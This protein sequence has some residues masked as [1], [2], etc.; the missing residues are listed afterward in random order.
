[1]KRTDNSNRR[2]PRWARRLG[3]VVVAIII[4]LVV[5]GVIA[6]HQYYSNLKPANPS[7]H[8][9]SVQIVAGST[10][11]QIASTLANQNI[12]KSQWVF[13]LYVTRAGARDELKAGTY[14]LSPAMNVGEIVSILS[15]GR[16][17]T[18]LVTIVPGSRLSQVQHTLIDAGFNK[19]DVATAL[20]PSTYQGN[21][22]LVDKPNNAGLEGFLY[23]DSFAKASNTKPQQIVSESL[24][25]MAKHLTPQLRAAFAK[26]GLNVY[27]GITL[28]S[29][30]E[31]EAANA[32]DRA[33]VAQVFLSRL[34]SGATLGSDV[35][36]F[37]G[38]SVAGKSDLSPGAQLKL[39]TPYNTLIHK[40]LPP[41]PISNVSDSSL[42]AAA[43]PAGTDW[44][45]FVAGDNGK[46][47]FS[48]TLDQH[49]QQ[50]Q[51]YCHKLCNV[52]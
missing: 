19:A 14:S 35:T 37:Y 43:H 2:L 48:T 41:G 4:I 51:E 38:A 9:R 3:I 31:Q 26:E 44:L 30:V 52:K 50:V 45:Y 28:A 40:G 39:D 32:N 8:S 27:Q 13:E 21:P 20:S 18:Q 29:I 23:P 25:E 24:A 11:S 49:E 1:M 16:V 42:A 6:R 34:D 5:G 33:Q 7:G 22:A 17:S 47:H 15:H 46:V 12:I 36:A 10:A